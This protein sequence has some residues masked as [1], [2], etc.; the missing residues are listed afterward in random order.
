MW[1]FAVSPTGG[2][3]WALVSDHEDTAKL[4]AYGYELPK[5]SED[6]YFDLYIRAKIGERWHMKAN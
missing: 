3:T 5:L 2:Q 4:V 1:A 6:E